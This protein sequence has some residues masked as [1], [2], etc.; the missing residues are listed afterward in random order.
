MSTIVATAIVVENPAKKDE[1]LLV[2]EKPRKEIPGIGGQYNLPAEQKEPGEMIIPCGMRAGKEETGYEVEPTHLIGVYHHP[3]VAGN[4]III[5]AIA[6]KIVGGKLH[7]REELPADILSA[8]W[9]PWE[10]I[11]SLRRQGKLVSH[12]VA[13]AILRYRYR[14]SEVLPLEAIKE[15]KIP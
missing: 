5:F 7:T 4:D 8:G 10:E 15:I 14:C 9:V 3:N 2:Q 12:Y 11:Q 6:A 1:F 13:L